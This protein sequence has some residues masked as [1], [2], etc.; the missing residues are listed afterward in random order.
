[1]VNATT[2]F[3]AARRNS[4][5]ETAGSKSDV[6]Q[7]LHIA[8]LPRRLANDGEGKWWRRHHIKCGVTALG[9]QTFGKRQLGE[10]KGPRRTARA[11]VQIGAFCG[12]SVIALT[13]DIAMIEI[14][15]PSQRT[16]RCPKPSVCMSSLG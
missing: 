7:Q 8:H 10:K 6:L 15:E 2:R 14:R 3:K 16:A 1:M 5:R 13:H 4:L 11:E 12:K 9:P